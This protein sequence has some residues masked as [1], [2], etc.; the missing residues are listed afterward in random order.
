MFFQVPCL[1][2]AVTKK[3]KTIQKAPNL[4]RFYFKNIFIKAFGLRQNIK[5]YVHFQV[6]RSECGALILKMFPRNFQENNVLIELRVSGI[7]ISLIHY[8]LNCGT[9]IF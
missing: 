5:L 4:N 6:V 7:P 9:V 1:W 2:Q 8:L 3:Q